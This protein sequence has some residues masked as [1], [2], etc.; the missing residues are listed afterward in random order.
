VLQTKEYTIDGRKLRL[1]QMSV[2]DYAT[3]LELIASD[4]TASD[5]LRTSAFEAYF[6]F[7]INVKGLKWFQF[8]KRYRINKL[9]KPVSLMERLSISQLN[10]IDDIVCE[11]MVV[12]KKKVLAE[13]KSHSQPPTD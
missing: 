8:I 3:L 6:S 4:K 1:S 11:L 7:K 12:D 13:I 5:S 10:E 2:K 9:I